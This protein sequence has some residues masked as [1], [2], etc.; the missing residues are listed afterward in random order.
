MLVYVFPIFLY[1]FFHFRFLI[2]LI[3]ILKILLNIGKERM[4]ERMKKENIYTLE[5]MKEKEK[6][7][8]G[9]VLCV[10]GPSKTIFI[11]L[12]RLCIL[13]NYDNLHQLLTLEFLILFF[14]FQ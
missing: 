1:I 13:M 3:S 14:D 5:D 2:K 7:K 10:C 12:M 8:I 9:F 11:S 4:E 6:I